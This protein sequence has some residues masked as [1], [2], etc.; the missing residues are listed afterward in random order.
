MYENA[1]D[2]PPVRRQFHPHQPVAGA[3]R[4]P[5]LAV[6]HRVRRGESVAVRVHQ[7]VPDGVDL[8]GLRGQDGGVLQVR[9]KL[10]S[11]FRPC[12]LWTGLFLSRK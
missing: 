7:L 12:P 3:L 1:H 10:V 11:V 4:K 5:E 9:N 6:V 8:E 2:Y